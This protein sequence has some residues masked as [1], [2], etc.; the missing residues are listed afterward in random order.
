ME[1]LWLCIRNAKHYEFSNQSI[2]PVQLKD[3]IPHPPSSDSS[4]SV[5]V[6]AASSSSSLAS[7]TRTSYCKS[8][9]STCHYLE[10]ENPPEIGGYTTD[11]GYSENKQKGHDDDDVPS[12]RVTKIFGRSCYFELL[13]LIFF[14]SDFDNCGRKRYRWPFIQGTAGMGSSSTHRSSYNNVNG[15]PF[16]VDT[17]NSNIHI[18]YVCVCCVDALLC[19][20]L[21]CRQ[22]D[23]YFLFTICY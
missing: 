21:I 19:V 5:T 2:T 7:R 16:H 1:Q 4:D 3:I 20:C 14:A 22:I 15:T 10:L 8:S 23:V 12:I 9:T 11:L 6:D 17:S 18:I 13:S